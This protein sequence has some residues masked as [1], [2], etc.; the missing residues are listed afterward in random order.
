MTNVKMKAL[1]TLH[2]SSV[3]ADNLAPGEEFEVSSA[4]ADDLEER[5][6]AKRVGGKVEAKAEKAAPE[7]KMEAPSEDKGIIGASA[8]DRDG[9]GRVGGSRKRGV[10][11]GK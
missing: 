7:N 11:G 5:G 8:F 3:Q 2:I 6:L 10:K 4:I 9:D 1:D